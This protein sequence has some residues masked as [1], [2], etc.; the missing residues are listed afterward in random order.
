VAEFN[1]SQLYPSTHYM[2]VY[3]ATPDSGFAWK[4]WFAVTAVAVACAAGYHGLTKRGTARAPAVPVE[5]PA[6]AA[7]ASLGNES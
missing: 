5:A 1:E 6:S 2:G 3:R 7:S 4:T